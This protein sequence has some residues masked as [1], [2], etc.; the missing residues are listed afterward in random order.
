MLL[1][2]GNI[3]LLKV[4]LVVKVATQAVFDGFSIVQTANWR[5]NAQPCVEKAELLRH[6]CLDVE[7]VHRCLRELLPENG[8]S[9][10]KVVFKFHRH[11]TRKQPIDASDVLIL[12]VFFEIRQ[13]KLVLD[14]LGAQLFHQRVNRG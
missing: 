14:H 9:F 10:F 4:E 12:E 8:T 3:Q 5:E 1:L 6:D 7:F 11:R 13:N 2:N